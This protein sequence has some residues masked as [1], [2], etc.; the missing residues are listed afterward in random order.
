MKFWYKQIFQYIYIQKKMI[1]T[2]IRIYSYQKSYIN[3]IRT[4]ICIG[5]YS[6]LFEY[7]NIRH[8]LEQKWGAEFVQPTSLLWLD[9][10]AIRCKNWSVTFCRPTIWQ[11][12]KP[13][14][15]FLSSD[16]CSYFPMRFWSG[17]WWWKALKAF[18]EGISQWICLSLFPVFVVAKVQ[19]PR[20]L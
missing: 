5:K 9:V 6:N 7:P 11:Q 8:T 2:N 13:S 16:P 1:Q 10:R 12:P 15:L 14:N 4:N 18:F 20:E 17:S 19:F 3:M